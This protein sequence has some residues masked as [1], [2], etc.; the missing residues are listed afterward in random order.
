MWRSLDFHSP[1]QARLTRGRT[2]TRALVL[3]ALLLTS[4]AAHGASEVYST[5]S[6][7]QPK[8]AQ[9]KIEL[10]RPIDASVELD[11]PLHAPLSKVVLALQLDEQGQVLGVRVVSG[12]EPFVSMAKDAAPR[13]RFSPARR[14]GKA[15]ACQ[16]LYEVS[17]LLRDSPAQDRVPQV[18][19][20]AGTS[21]AS[22]GS[23]NSAIEANLADPSRI[24][25]P[26]ASLVSAPASP[27]K[28][29]E[30]LPVEVRVQGDRTPP[31]ALSLTAAEAR[32]IPGSFGDPLRAVESLPSVTPIMSGLPYFYVRGAPPGNVGYFVD[33]VR[34]PLLWHALVG[35]SVIHPAT[36]E[37][38]TLNRGAY[39]VEYG[40]FAGAVVTADTVAPPP[41]PHGEVGLRLIDASAMGASSLG[42]VGHRLPDATALAAAR[43]S[44]SGLALSLLSSQVDLG[45][46]DYQLIT[47]VPVSS[48]GTLGLLG[49]GA[50][51]Y[52]STSAG[53]SS[54]QYHRADVRY[55]H[56]FPK[57][58]IRVATT[59]GRDKAGSD[60]GQASDN[61]TAVRLQ[62]EYWVA[63][64]LT[65]RVGADAS[66]DVHALSLSD[67]VRYQTATLLG[68]AMPTRQDV[69]LGVYAALDYTPSPRL[70]VTPG[71][72]VDRYQSGDQAAIGVDPRIAA[73]YRLS[74]RVSTTHS[75]GVAHQAAVSI[76]GV[77]AAQVTS[78]KGGLQRSIQAS[79]GVNFDFDANTRMSAE[80]FES[81]YENLAD[82]LGTT[83]RLS[84]D[85]DA[86][87]DRVQG[88]AYGAEIYIK[89]KISHRVGGFLSYTFSRS[90]RSF[91]RI[92]TLSALDRTHVVNVAL[93]VD[94]GRRWR[95]GGRL[96]GLGGLPV[97]VATTSGDLH[98]GST[99][100]TPFIR[101][102]LRAEKRWNFSRGLWGAAVFELMNATF[103][104]EVTELSCNPIRCTETRV[105][106]IVLP[107]IGGE[108]HF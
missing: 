67:S 42:S 102:D 44:Y 86:S 34:V 31:S 50:Y 28:P 82:P 38:V 22:E 35:P 15:T 29:T 76:P 103:S 91:G 18:P 4:E 3:G 2:F 73:R 30:R 36:L 106:P 11:L 62:A 56:Q 88:A 72:R 41:E 59:V 10:P 96:T 52:L 7:A 25:P 101:L 84:L 60:R 43:Y 89:R 81:I 97:R 74:S 104:Q 57:G 65:V 48:H 37:K 32:E 70:L 45:Y 90:T 94:L 16:F 68:A 46:W 47:Q 24:E 6:P 64:P 23:A 33:G 49:L 55:D 108:L 99:R 39:P 40:R 83:H 75:V 80:L 87:S 98:D 21:S 51:D 100:S 14:Q 69:T 8:D 13:F 1:R 71:I 12:E 77:P 85:V 92:A 61:L 20:D 63:V 9:P 79:S 53:A 27:Q 19:S 78:L 58:K 95:L 17:W 5:S 26:K 66:R 105:G 54:M 93:A 107:S